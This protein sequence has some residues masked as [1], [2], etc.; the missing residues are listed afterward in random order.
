MLNNEYKEKERYS[1]DT[2][3]I[4][5]LLHDVC[6]IDTYSQD[7]EKATEAQL[8]YL[9]D[10]VSKSGDK[11]PEKEYLTKAYATKLIDYYK[12]GRNGVNADRSSYPEFS[13]TWKYDDKL[14]MGHGE[15]SVY[16]VQKFIQLTE[17]EA[18]AIR[19]HQEDYAKS[20]GHSF[21]DRTYSQAVNLCSL[22]PLIHTADYLVSLFVDKKV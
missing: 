15:K 22:I 2:V 9:W 8:K 16:L 6:K 3:I 11:E 10:L 20:D 13:P 18:L 17:T 1:E 19:W 21:E 12:N 5:A 4:A 7:S 14:P